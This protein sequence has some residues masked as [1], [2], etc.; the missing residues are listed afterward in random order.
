MISAKASQATFAIRFSVFYANY[1]RHGK[2]QTT[3][4]N[5]S[6]EQTS[7]LC[8]LMFLP[9]TTRHLLE[10]ELITV[11]PSYSVVYYDLSLSVYQGFTKKK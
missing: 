2:V 10:D 8:A 9:A 5:D 11:E 6:L 7:G 4:L 3:G 1:V